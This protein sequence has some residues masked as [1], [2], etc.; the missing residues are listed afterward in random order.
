MKRPMAGLTLY[1]LAALASATDWTLSP[2]VVTGTGTAALL[3]DSPVAVQVLDRTTIENSQAAT[4][5]ELL[6]R[7]PGL[8]LKQTHGQSGASVMLNGLTE[9]HVLILVDGVPLNQANASGV[10][11]RALKLADIERIEVVSAN[12]SALYGSAAMGGVIHLITRAPM[13]PAFE[14]GIQV[15]QAEA[16]WARYPTQTDVDAHWAQPFLGGYSATSVAVTRYA[17]FDSEPDTWA[18]DEPH[19]LGWTLSQSWRYDGDRQHQ[20]TGRWR[21]MA[22]TLPGQHALTANPNERR[23]LEQFFSGQYQLEG[24]ASRW[25]FNGQYASGLSEHDRLNTPDVDLERRYQAWNGAVDARRQTHWWNHEQ[26]WGVRLSAAALA[27]QK[28]EPGS[29]EVDEI[30]PSD[31][32]SLELYAQ[33]DWFVTDRVELISGVRGHW[34]PDFGV[35]LAPNLASRI[36]LSARQFVRASLGLGYRVPDL[37]ERFYEF[38]HS[39]YG[40]RVLGNPEL[41]PE[42][43]ISAQLEWVLGDFS[44]EGF[45][46]DVTDLIS[47]DQVGTDDGGVTRHQYINID[48]AEI[49][50]VNLRAKTELGAHR[51]MAYGQWLHAINALTGDALPQ[52]PEYLVDLSHQ[53]SFHWARPQRLQTSLKRL[54]PQFYGAEETLPVDAYTQVNVSWGIELTDRFRLNAGVDNLSN[55]QSPSGGTADA[56]PI[57]GRTYGVALR[58]TH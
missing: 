53:W 36:D 11:T 23:T 7:M 55:V 56:L 17:G 9:K 43:S 38:D 30:A 31:Q 47:T 46:R 1:Y 13:E 22:L 50:G 20:V 33:D 52:R 19:G 16:D 28:I 27:Q 45:Y 57:R 14:M 48:E 4:L 37:K 15:R 58:Y 8:Q 5:E 49:R 40:Y 32:V 42:K 44:I 35:F 39:L 24:E 29:G 18:E 41:Q 25:L 51:F 26:I 34:D 10:D 2:I 12:A 6:E 54:G 21:G 3:E